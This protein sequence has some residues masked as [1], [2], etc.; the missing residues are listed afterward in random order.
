[1]ELKEIDFENIESDLHGKNIIYGAGHNGRIVYELLVERGVKIETFYDDD[2]TR[3]GEKYCEKNILSRQQFEFLDRNM[4][5]IIIAS[6]YTEK[7]IHKLDFYGFKRV[8][9]VLQKL[10]EVAS[11]HLRFSEYQGNQKYLEQIENLICS[12]K[13]NKTR[14]Y[15]EVI[16]QS[17][18]EGKPKKEIIDLCCREEQYFLDAFM[19]KL[20]GLNFID[21]G[22]YTGDTVR[23]VQERKIYP[24]KIYCFEADKDNYNK[25]YNYVKSSSRLQSKEYV[26][27]ENY[28]L[29][30]SCVM[31]GMRRSGYNACVDI[32][33]KSAVVPTITID[34]YFANIHVGFVK[35]DIEGAEQRALL[36]GM[37]V[38]KRD[39]PLLA[40]SIYHSLDDIV[41]I[42][43]MLMHQLSDYHFIVRS[44]S[45]TYSEA[46]LYG[47]PNESKIQLK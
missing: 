6:M 43:Q 21:G 32:S 30:D 14:Q 20:D 26:V 4:T 8:Y 16:E 24:A 15:F 41:E 40:I 39:R 28:A 47:V 10:L 36:G 22:A 35:M 46:V 18:V 34:K 45:N 9:T 11:G 7:I 37:N 29:W 31:I 33:E 3:W 17:V 5:N 19:G 13:D 44:H 27:C 38:L 25:L 12:T 42:P 2:V 1:M 23:E